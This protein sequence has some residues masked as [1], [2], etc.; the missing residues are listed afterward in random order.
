MLL[1]WGWVRRRTEAAV[2]E[3]RDLETR[4]LEAWAASEAAKGRFDQTGAARA[5]DEGIRAWTEQGGL[6]MAAEAARG[7]AL[8]AMQ[9]IPPASTMYGHSELPQAG[10]DAPQW[11]AS[12]ASATRAFFGDHQYPPGEDWRQ[13]AKS[14]LLQLC[15][16]DQS[17]SILDPA[18]DEGTSADA[19]AE[20][21]AG[22]LDAAA[23]LDAL[24][25]AEPS[26]AA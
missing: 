16:E 2:E 23:V 7:E 25:R 10:S 15:A 3:A 21:A 20:A 13:W 6:A 1:R 4:R 11:D 26:R 24:A 18:D 17:P 8:Q 5:V 9:F 14:A 19:R 12:V 22:N